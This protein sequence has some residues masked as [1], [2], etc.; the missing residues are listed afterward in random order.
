MAF[1]HAH[2]AG[3]SYDLLD[4]CEGVLIKPG[5]KAAGYEASLKK[6]QKADKAAQK[7]I[8]TIIKKKPLDLFLS[9]ATAKE[10]WTELNAVYDIK[11]DENLSLV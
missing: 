6:F 3:R 11:S 1:H 4:V 2:I 10:M 7:L 9:C 8:V 5:S